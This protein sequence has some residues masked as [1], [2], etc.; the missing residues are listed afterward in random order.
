MCKQVASTYVM[1]MSK[2]QKGA[3]SVLR[4][5]G[6]LQEFEVK[7][8]RKLV[9]LPKLRPTIKFTFYGGCAAVLY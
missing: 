2:R 5:V 1:A 8:F 3:A 7:E 6:L 9:C 4:K